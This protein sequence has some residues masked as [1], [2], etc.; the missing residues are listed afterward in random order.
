MSCRAKLGGFRVEGKM[1]A[2]GRIHEHVT[3]SEWIASQEWSPWLRRIRERKDVDVLEAS[4]HH[5][6]YYQRGLAIKRNS[7]EEVGGY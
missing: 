5:W 6:Y 4:W 2:S 1:L 3:E 7:H